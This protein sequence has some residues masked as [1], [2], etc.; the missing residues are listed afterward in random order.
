MQSKVTKDIL[1]F[2]YCNKIH[3]SSILRIIISNMTNMYDRY[4]NIKYI[5]KEI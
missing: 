4:I 3:K 2:F 5:L 1:S